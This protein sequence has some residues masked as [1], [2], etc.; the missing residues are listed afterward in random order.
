MG[1]SHNKNECIYCSS[2]YY[3]DLIF[4]RSGGSCARLFPV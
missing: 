2:R 3:W 4:T 1:L